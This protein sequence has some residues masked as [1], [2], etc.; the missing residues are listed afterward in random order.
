LDSL[1]QNG[2]LHLR[3]EQ[4]CHTATGLRNPATRRGMLEPSFSGRISVSFLP[5]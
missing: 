5:N 4:S 2:Q 3:H 1:L